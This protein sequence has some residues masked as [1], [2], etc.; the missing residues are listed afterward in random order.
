MR[1]VVGVAVTAAYMA[2]GGGKTPIGRFAV[3]LMGAA[4]LG[5]GAVIV[6]AA[7]A[8]AAAEAALSEPP[9]PGAAAVRRR[10]P[11]RRPE[12][13]W[14]QAITGW[15]YS[16]PVGVERLE[17]ITYTQGYALDVYRPET[18]GTEPRPALL[19]VHGGSWS[20]GDKRRSG[21]PLIHH[22]AEAGWVVV[23]PNYPLSPKAT[24]PDHLIGLK[25]VLVWMR[26]HGQ[27]FGIDAGA[28]AVAGGSSGA[29]L[30]ALLALTPGEERYQP[31]FESADTSVQAAAV[32]YGVYDLLNRN[33][34][35]DDWPVIPRV[36]MKR[37]RSEDPDG[38]PRGLPARSGRATGATV[39]RGA[40]RQR[41]AG[42]GEREHPIRRCAA[43]CL[44]SRGRIPR[45]GRCHPRIRQHSPR[46]APQ[47][48][49][50]G[51]RR[52]LERALYR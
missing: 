19:Y 23:V 48:V 47:S 36:L 7:R 4:M 20:N 35:R 5:S 45:G 49:V 38:L 17:D 27:E 37:R 40:R 26:T 42:P 46:S 18:P 8:G 12:T 41:L 21:M 3:G 29:H 10:H 30:A 14:L 24:F 1:L 11:R 51:V 31:G 33:R 2:A 28:V 25:R 13:H 6:I 16:V 32:F 43:S 22:L 15:P 44:G 9:G 39:P 50:R 52:F 34:T